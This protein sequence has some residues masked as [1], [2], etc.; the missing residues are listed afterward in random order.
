VFTSF[1]IGVRQSALLALELV[2]VESVEHESVEA[3]CGLEVA[4]AVGAVTVAL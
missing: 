3:F 1:I 2:S 4:L